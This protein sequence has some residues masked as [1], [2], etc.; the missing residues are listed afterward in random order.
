MNLINAIDLATSKTYKNERRC[1]IGASNVGNPC[2][3]FLQYSLRGYSQIGPPP[4]VIRIFNLGHH[5]EEIVVEDLK[6][7]GISVSEINPKTGK[8][9]TFTALGGHVRGH[10]GGAAV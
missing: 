6:A 9:W 8:Q 10:S 1:Y 2:H 5:L 7:A 4:A 3:A